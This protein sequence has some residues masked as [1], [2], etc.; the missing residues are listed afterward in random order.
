[1]LLKFS[2]YG[3]LKNLRFFEPFLYL[4]FLENGLSFFQI[5]LLIGLREIFVNLLEIPTGAIADLTGR[6]RAMAFAF[7]S[8]IISFSIFYL[9]SSFPLF[10]VAMIL[11][12]GGE[13]FRSGTHKS[14]IMEY[15]DIEDREEEKV[16]YYGK[17]RSA[18][19]L[20]S[21]LSALL[22][23]LIVYFSGN[24]NVIFLATIL[25]YSL[26]LILMLTYPRELDGLEGKA[27]PKSLL[28]ETVLH[29]KQSF[30]SILETPE[31]AKTLN[32]ASIFDSIFK[33]GKDYLQPILRAQALALPFL[34]FIEDSQSRA[35]ILIGIVY[36]FIYIGSFVSSRTSSSFMQKVGDMPR[37]LN[38]LLWINA[39]ALLAAGLSLQA[40]FRPLAIFVFLIFYVLY[41]LRKPMVVGFLGDRIENRQRAT[42]L[43]VHSQLRSLFGMIIAPIFGLLADNLG[44]PAIFFFAFALLAVTGLFLSFGEQVKEEG[45]AT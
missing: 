26:D 33:I 12:A 35:S 6:R 44:L 15:L 30:R 36:F 29:F 1:M 24:Y 10:V 38:A 14:M 2:A 27:R 45:E 41:N 42:V 18:S 25:P 31:L 8:Y 9:T 4:F 23:A 5:G 17:T 3:F 16:T 34:L 11:F 22:A 19:R 7:A 32:N 37:A 20:G 39:A 43:S 28:R 13:A 40:D 21:A